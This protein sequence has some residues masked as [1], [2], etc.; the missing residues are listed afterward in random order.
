MRLNKKFAP[1]LAVVMM[2]S[3]A[4]L[5]ALAA[6]VETV[7]DLMSAK[8]GVQSGTVAERIIKLLLEG[9]SGEVV[10][11]GKVRE[12]V[13]ALKEHKVDVA[14]MDETSARYFAITEHE[15]LRLLFREPVSKNLP[16]A[17]AFR[18]GDALREKV[19]K[20][21]AEL[22]ADGTRNKIIA[23]YIVGNPAP[24]EIDFNRGDDREALWV[25]CAADFPPYDMRDEHGF[26]GI[27]IELC[28]AI[29]KKLGMEL[30][31]ADYSFEDLAEALLDG[32]IDMICSAVSVNEERKEFLDFSEPYDAEQ[33]LMVVL[34]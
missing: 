4:A 2:L 15:S 33:I 8:V 7:E 26:Y 11:F 5:P 31:I 34:K 22:K 10:S 23:K 24:V 3:V 27:D 20:A 6:R 29:A 19:N 18:K 21:L 28:A 14:V 1:V 32:K 12:V 25:G 17:I 16:Y 9:S 13:D 30:K